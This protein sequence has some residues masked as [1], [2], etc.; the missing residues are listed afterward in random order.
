[1]IH[2]Q[3]IGKVYRGRN[4]EVRALQG[5]NLDVPP[6]QFLS[7]IGKSGS[8]KSSLL[9]IIGLLD[10][11]YN[12]LYR[13]DDADYRTETDAVVTR[14]RKRIG[15]IFQDF[16]LVGRYTIL[17][18]L[19]VAGVLREGAVQSD[20]ILEYL[21]RVGLADKASSYPDELSGGQKQRAAIA[22]ALIGRPRLIIA[23]EPTGSLDSATAGEVLRL[24][25]D[26]YLTLG[27]TLLLVTHDR[28]I[29]DHAERTIELAAGKVAREIF[30]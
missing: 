7:I 24:L 22:R 25:E 20:E 23:D 26:V 12:G 4:F 8:G 19:Q 13:F 27:C 3:N 30:R 9:K 10:L 2:L 15:Y 28:E 1:L 5:V 6:G 21:D 18:N 16:Q 17:K 29:A 11:D 14:A